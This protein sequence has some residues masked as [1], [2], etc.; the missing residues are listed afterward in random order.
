[1]ARNQSAAFRRA[2]YAAQTGEA[3]VVLLTIGHPSLTDPIRVCSAGEDLVSRG[4]TYQSYPFRIA[5]PDEADEA[6]RSVTLE[7]DNV[8]RRIVEALRPL[9]D[10]MTVTM[11]LVLASQPDV[12]DVGPYYLALRD[13]RY[14]Q[15]VVSGELQPE[16]LLNEPWPAH[17]YTPSWFPGVFKGGSGGSSS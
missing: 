10:A 12:V 17:S 3:A 11:E 14:D 8:D 2:I 5:L 1:M 7:I 4:A 16:D 6:P 15:L 13:V 9:S